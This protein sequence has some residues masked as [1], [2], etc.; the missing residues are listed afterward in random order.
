GLQVS[1]RADGVGKSDQFTK[2]PEL[3]G[4]AYLQ[5][6]EFC[7]RE[8]N[9]DAHEPRVGSGGVSIGEVT[10]HQETTVGVVLHQNVASSRSTTMRFG[11]TRAPELRRALT[12]T[13]GQLTR[14]ARGR[15][16]EGLRCFMATTSRRNFRRSRGE[17]A[18]T[19]FKSFDAL[20]V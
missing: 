6:M 12:S 1:Q 4:V 2:H 20:I 5:P 7:E 14:P 9:P 8:G 11:S 17:S 16:R 13:F 18:L 15:E 3:K 10:R 19:C